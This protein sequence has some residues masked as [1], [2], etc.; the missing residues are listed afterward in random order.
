MGLAGN[1]LRVRARTNSTY[2]R[3]VS[4]LPELIPDMSTNNCYTF[5]YALKERH[6]I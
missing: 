6:V 3:K 5:I 2:L 1:G 4:S